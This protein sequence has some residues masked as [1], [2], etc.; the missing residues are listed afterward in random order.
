MKSEIREMNP[1]AVADKLVELSPN[2][3]LVQAKCRLLIGNGRHNA[4]PSIARWQDKFWLAYREADAH[5]GTGEIIILNSAD[6]QDWQEVQRINIAPDNRD[7]QFVVAGD[8][9]MFYFVTAESLDADRIHKTYA[10]STT[11]GKTFE[12]HGQVCEDHYIFWRPIYHGGTFYCAAYTTSPHR[13]LVLVKSDDGLQW[14]TVLP[15]G[16]IDARQWSETA[17]RFTEGNTIQAFLRM[18][19]SFSRDDPALGE[20]WECKPPYDQ[21]EHVRTLPFRLGGPGVLDIDGHTYLFSR[22][23]N[24]LGACNAMNIF[25]VDGDEVRPHCS[26]PCMRDA[27]YG[28]AVPNGDQ[29][30]M[31]FYC[32]VPDGVNLYLADVPLAR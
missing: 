30:L 26:I 19:F 14:E 22:G 25:L 16:D 21:W 2:D 24:K 20:V 8:R 23:H 4:F 27:A 5:A 28:Q 10:S 11:D 6:A 29:M 17:I 12:I 31:V 32:T 1:S 3:K 15:F 13:S 9:L 18:K 7:A